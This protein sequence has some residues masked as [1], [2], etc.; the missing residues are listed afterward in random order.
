MNHYESHLLKHL[1]YARSRNIEHPIRPLQVHD[2]VSGLKKYLNYT[3]D[4]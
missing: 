2:E 4:Y 1:T 3:T